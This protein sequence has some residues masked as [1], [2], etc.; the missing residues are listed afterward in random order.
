M[1]ASATTAVLDAFFTAYYRRCPVSAT[2]I[3][4]HDYD[5]RLPDYSE[6][7]MADAAAEREAIHR[8]LRALPAEPLTQAE[9]LDRTI[10]E[11]CLEIQAWEDGAPHF[12]R[13]NPC[14]YT[15]EA[16][17]GVVSL[18]LRPFAPLSQRV[19]AATA[20]MRGIAT[21][22]AQGKTNVRR[23]PGA[24]VERAIRECRGARA[25]FGSGVRILM[26]DEAIDDPRFAAAAE[27][28]AASFAEFQAHLEQNLAPGADDGCACGEEAL[29]LL[30]RRGHFLEADAGEVR[31]A[32]EERMAACAAE[33]DGQAAG[34]GARD[35]REA[36]ALLAD[37]HPPAHGYYA[38]FAEVWAKARAA[39]EAAGLVT[40]PDFPIRFV[41]QP[42]WAREAAP[43][44]YFLAYRSPAPYDASP[45][46]D[47][48]VPP[49]ETTM[50][51]EEQTRRLRATNDSVI[52][53]N[54]VIHHGG[55]GHHV[56]NWYARRAASRTGQVAAVDCASRIALFCGGTMAEGW[57]CYA[58]DLME[59]IGFL[60]PLERYAQVH[61]RMRM[62]A[63]ALVDVDLH[64]GVI[65]LEAAA[66]LYARRIGLSPEAA[67]AEA[68]KNSMFPGTALMYMMGTDALHRLRRD[69]A[70]GSTAFDLR[71]FHDRVLA[72]G[73]VPVALVAGA[74]RRE[75]TRPASPEIRRQ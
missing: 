27:A 63:R 47:Y 41:P 73:S 15:G 7:A 24:W 11:G 70:F 10:V 69:L 64:R 14:V 74:M 29:D 45:V 19:E 12:Y 68:V 5:D 28:A 34:F 57:A 22:L 46:V 60:T 61:A 62:A 66:A 67:R 16:I 18:F 1:A 9:G 30:L 3:G 39:A 2:F 59:E 31:A 49:V 20:R 44:L 26:R 8:R 13:G 40:W 48:L 32:A 37:G 55:L 25:F 50:P 21:L 65:S 38:R 23:A 17:F 54:H 36:L 35:W 6:R 43:Y 53:Q 75:H 33:L 52:K 4:V 71:R 58:T 56:Q 51:P 42:A 72:H